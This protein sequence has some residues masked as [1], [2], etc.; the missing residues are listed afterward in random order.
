M[1]ALRES[2]W[3][4]LSEPVLQICIE[5]NENVNLN[6]NH[7]Q[8]IWEMRVGYFNLGVVCSSPVEMEEFLLQNIHSFIP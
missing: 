2:T 6:L 4:S 3:G 5:E 8:F 7:I 1:N